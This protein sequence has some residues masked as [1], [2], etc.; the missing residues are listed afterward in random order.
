MKQCDGTCSTAKCRR[1]YN[2][3]MRVYMSKRYERRRNDFIQSR[4]G[5]CEV[6]GCGSTDQ[7]EVDHRDRKQKSFDVGKAFAG[8]SQA[9][10]DKELTK[11]WVLCHDCHR[12]KT[13][14]ELSVEHGGGASGKRNCPCEKCRTR[15]REYNKRYS[16]TKH[17]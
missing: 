11:C 3:Y 7:L 17:P 8:W 5:V 1:C 13:T 2:E 14:S 15:K 10:L 16:K 4:G 6:P 9:R 12:T